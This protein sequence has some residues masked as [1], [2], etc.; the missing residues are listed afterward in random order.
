MKRL[1]DAAS[2][3]AAAVFNR[4]EAAVNV[5]LTREQL[6][7]DAARGQCACVDL[8]DV[9]RHVDVA[10]SVRG[11]LLAVLQVQPHEARVVRARCC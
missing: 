8:R 4:G 5:T 2:P 10:T 9:D 11:A 3:R 7:L 6:G 1:A